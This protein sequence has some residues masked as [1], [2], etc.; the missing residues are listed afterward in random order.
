M[1]DGHNRNFAAGLWSLLARPLAALGLTP[2]QVTLLGLV[3]VLGNCGAYLWHR[4]N[5]LFG[6]G[7]ALSFVFDALDGAVARQT[8]RTTKFGGYLDAVVDRYQEIAVYFV[9]GWATGW[10]PLCFLAITG[11]LLTS[12][13]KARTAVEMP[14]ENNAWPDLMERLERIVVICAA[15]ILDPFLRFSASPAGR[16]LFLGLAAIAL[17]SHITAIQRFWRA[18]TLIRRHETA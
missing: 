10:W 3:L 13:N 17:F 16:V 11:S 8:G 2:N 12:Y 9:L 14:I 1:I 18:R 5:L 4:S 15:L 7:L 6:L